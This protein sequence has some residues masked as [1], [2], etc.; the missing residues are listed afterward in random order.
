VL[1]RHRVLTAI[2]IL[3]IAAG[4]IPSATADINALRPHALPHEAH[5]RP[6]ELVCGVILREHR[7]M[8]LDIIEGND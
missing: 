3:D 6:E 2:R 1:P 4:R 5:L 7:R 8:R